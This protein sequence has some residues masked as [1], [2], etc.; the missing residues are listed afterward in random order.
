M[1]L[2]KKNEEAF[3][4]ISFLILKGSRPL[5]FTVSLYHF[6]CPLLRQPQPLFKGNLTLVI[7][8]KLYMLLR[9]IPPQMVGSAATALHLPDFGFLLSP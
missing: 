9:L 7:N 2:Y 1:Y 8:S 6:L 3:T 4:S 5:S